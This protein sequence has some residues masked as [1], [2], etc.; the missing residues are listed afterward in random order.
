MID[1]RVRENMALNRDK[2]KAEFI[3][4]TPDRGLMMTM[5]V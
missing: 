1:S 2:W 5:T 4:L 3:K